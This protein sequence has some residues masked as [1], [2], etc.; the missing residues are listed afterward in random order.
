MA[1]GELTVG[2]LAVLTRE[3]AD[4]AG[5]FPR[6][7][8]K[9]E[10]TQAINEWISGELMTLE[11]RQ[12][13]EGLGLV[14]IAL[15]RHTPISLRGFTSLGLAEDEAWA[16]LNELVKTVRLQGAI[17]VLDRV[18]VKDETVRAAQYTSPHALDGIRQ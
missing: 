8:G 10:I 6:H 11:T 7:M 15:Q 4:A 1:K 3:K 17:T 9:I 13:L 18:D 14:K 5:H 12:S 16:L 2:D